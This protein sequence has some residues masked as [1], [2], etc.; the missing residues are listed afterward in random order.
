[1]ASKRRRLRG[2][3][4]CPV[5]YTVGDPPGVLSMPSSTKRRRLW[6]KSRPCATVAFD[7]VSSFLLCSGSLLAVV[8]CFAMSPAMLYL[9]CSNRALFEAFRGEVRDIRVA[10]YVYRQ[11]VLWSLDVDLIGLLRH[12]FYERW[13]DYDRLV[14][15]IHTKCYCYWCSGCRGSIPDDVVCTK[16]ERM[17]F[18]LSPYYVEAP[19]EGLEWTPAGQLYWPLSTRGSSAYDMFEWVNR[20]YFRLGYYEPNI[21]PPE[22]LVTG[23]TVY[24]EYRRGAVNYGYP[25]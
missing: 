3:T 19:Y 23:E 6:I 12:E 2:K 11:H 18:A 8:E 14:E 13:P 9:Y 10:A 22:P 4:T 7:Y 20:C 21:P 5:G 15:R 1:M 16:T 25:D 24:A 17:L